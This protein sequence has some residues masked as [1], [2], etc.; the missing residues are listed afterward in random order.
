MKEAT[1]KYLWIL[2]VTAVG[3]A[4]AGTYGLYRYI[5]YAPA[6]GQNDDYATFLPK[7]QEQYEPRLREL[8]DR[9]NARSYESVSIQS[10]DG[11]RLNG[12]YYHTR[13]GA[14][15]AILVHGYR[16][17][18]SRDFCGGA[19]MCFGMGFNVLLI[20]HRA[21]CNSEGHT[22]SF[23]VNERFDC[24]AW[25][26]WAAERFHCPI[27]LSG[28][29]MGAASVLMASELDLPE[30]VRG[31]VA[32][33]PYSSPSEIIRKVGADQ[34]FPVALTYPL[35]RLGARVF[36][37]FHL[38]DSAAIDAVR[39][40]R[41]PILLIHGEA[42][43]FVPCDMGRAIAAANP[44]KVEMHTFPGAWHGASYLVDPERY[45]QLVRDF[46]QRVTA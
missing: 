32:D 22:I 24:L 3:A 40:T 11:L 34:G 9:L 39:H 35:A 27:L 17:T 1:K 15:L 38:E 18:P 26:R 19:E 6:K 41:V 14:P 44:E 29:S 16:G 31:I 43:T 42:D 20:E 28:I 36:G 12:R 4:V 2:P 7:G 45:T 25:C 33:C 10:Y 5:F 21:H 46:W 37:E 23:G 13:D 30:N 8:V